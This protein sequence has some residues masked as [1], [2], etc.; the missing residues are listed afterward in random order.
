[1]YYPLISLMPKAQ[2]LLLD[3]YS[4]ETVAYSLRKLRTDYS[5]SAIRVRRASDN[6]EQDIEFDSSGN[7]DVNSIKNF[8]GYNLFSYSEDLAQ[9][10]WIKTRTTVTTDT[11]VAPDGLTT[12]DIVFESVA[13]GT[14]GLSRGQAVINGEDYS[15]SF[16]IK[17]EGRSYFQI[18]AANNLSTDIATQPIA[19]LD[20]TSETVI[21]D[22]GF[23]RVSPTITSVGSGWYKIEYGLVANSTTTS[24]AFLVEYSTNGTT[25]S[26]VGDVTKGMAIWGLQISQTSVVKPYRQTL[27]IAEGM[28]L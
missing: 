13:S 2:A 28:D 17:G 14:H 1:M 22:N 10:V 24:T 27:A 23:F 15:V 19:M 9:S 20:L 26:Y 12:A 25:T 3:T 5:G 8:V 21:S 11:V 7:L 4:G 16:Y 6:T 18:R